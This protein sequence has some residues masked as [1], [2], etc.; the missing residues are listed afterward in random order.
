MT[1]A[2]HADGCRILYCSP[3][4][5]APT[6]ITFETADGERFGIVA[7]AFLAN[8]RLTK[9]RPDDEHRLQVKY[10]SRDGK[11]HELWQDP[12]GLYTTLFL[13]INPEQ[14]F[15]VG[16]DPVL[17]SP[18][19]MFIS[20]EFKQEQADAI[21]QT[22]WHA[23]ERSRKTADAGPIE[24]LVGGRPERFLDYVRFERDALAEDQGQRQLLAERAG[25]SPLRPVEASASHPPDL[26]PSPARLHDLAR[27]FE[28]SQREVMDL[29]ESAPRLK[30]AV[31]GWVAE[32]HLYRQV[33]GVPDVSECKRITKE[34]GA[35]IALRFRGAP[36]TIECKNVLRNTTAAGVAR[37][38]FQRTRASKGDPCS[39]YYSPRDFDVVAACLH[40][41]TERWEFRYVVPTRLAPHQRCPGKLGNNVRLDERWRSDAHRV[42]SEAAGL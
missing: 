22:G 14:R 8:Q 21:L 33:Q 18:T 1:D 9:N 37:V 6:R 17:H 30:M 7:Y 20:I 39:R 36:L 42:F 25:H 40:A 11:L 29:I 41:V 38:D 16:A 13:G 28:L 23:W 4:S 12:Y 3:P 34:G 19:K 27:E 2:L 35:D 24:V 15:F 31:R 10:G 32:E 26:V 5:E